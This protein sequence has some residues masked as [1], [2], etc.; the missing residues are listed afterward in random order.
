MPQLIP[1]QLMYMA[2]SLFDSPSVHTYEWL[3]FSLILIR[4]I[5]IWLSLCLISIQFTY[6]SFCSN[7]SLYPY[8]IM[9]LSHYYDLIMLFLYFGSG[10]ICT[11]LS[12]VLDLN[13]VHAY[14]ILAQPLLHFISRF[15]YIY[16]RS[17]CVA[18]L[19]FQISYTYI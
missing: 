3:C 16:I 5:Y 17:L 15:H 4:L 9:P 11:C 7:F 13:S 18:L 6:I 10:F 8:I 12:Q 2:I 1:I 19:C 14:V